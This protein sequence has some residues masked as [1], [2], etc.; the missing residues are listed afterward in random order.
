MIERYIGCSGYYYRDW[1]GIFYPEDISRS[2][3]FSYYSGVFNTVEINA[4]FYIF[5]KDIFLK[6]LYEN[7]PEKF[8]FSIKV[9]R[10]ITHVKKLKDSKNLIDRFYSTVEGKLKE[11]TGAFL[12]QM[13]PSFTFSE[14]NL[15][16]ILKITDTKR[17][18]VFEFRHIS[19]WNEKVFSIFEREGIIFCS[20]SAPKFPEELVKTGKAVY[21]R[22]HGKKEWYKDLYTEEDLLKWKEKILDKKPEKI[23]AYFNNTFNGYAVKNALYFKKI[24][25]EEKNSPQ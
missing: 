5:P 20:I 9:N 12:F 16:R 13:P 22:F 17:E 24:L 2:R 1:K 8:V 25:E 10:L 14:E 3:W 19:W 7:S 4:T 6:R 23:Y 21:I 11:K 18:N 15:D